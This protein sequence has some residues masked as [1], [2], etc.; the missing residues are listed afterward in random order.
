MTASGE[1][2]PLRYLKLTSEVAGRIQ[3]IYVNPGEQ[4]KKNQRLVVIDSSEQAQ[5][6]AQQSA[7][8]DAEKAR[9][10][11]ASAKQA[12]EQAD[13][14]VTQAK[15]DAVTAESDWK[16]FEREF[17]RAKD[18]LE[19]KVLSPSEYNAARDRVD[20]A[21][22]KLDDR[23]LALKQAS[24]RADQRR[25]VVNEAQTRAE[26]SAMRANYLATL[27]R[28]QSNRREKVTQVSL[29]DGI[30]ADIP[31]RAGEVVFGG[32][33][34]TTLMTIAD[35]SAIYVEVNVE[36][37]EISRVEVGQ[38]VTITVDAFGEKQIRGL[39][40][41][42]DPRPDADSNNRG[43]LSNR[44]NAPGPKEFRVMVEMREMSDEIRNRLRPGMSATATISTK[45]RK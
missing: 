28:G 3:E 42:K 30:V 14:A 12:W 29:L 4:V 6:A 31:T 8:N 33:T 36:E 7:I 18:L 26:A 34:G 5:S 20:R 21:R 38:Q 43:G 9:D 44:V 41:G 15:K 45:A 19:A 22:V 1:V 40:T 2:R 24:E 10:A 32:L 25:A 23:N 35:M 27:L 13:A 11:L 17:K 37:A 16:S 39:V